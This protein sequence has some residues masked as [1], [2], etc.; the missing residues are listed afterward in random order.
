MRLDA[1]GTD[2]RPAAAMRDAEGLVQV[3]VADV[4]AELGRAH[5]PDLGIEVGAV[6][7]DLTAIGMDG[8]ADFLDRRLEHAMGRGIGDHQGGEVVLVLG[9]LL[10]QVGDVDVAM[11]VAGHDDDLHARHDGGGRVG[12]MGRDG[13]EADVALSFT[14]RGVIAADGEQARIFALAAGIGLQRHGV[15][16]GDLRQHLLQLLEELLVAL[17]LFEGGE[18]MQHGEAAP[19]DGDH[20]RRGVELHGAGTQRNH[21][22][23]ERHVLHLQ[24]AEVAQHLG[25]R[26]IHREHRVGEVA[27][28]PAQWLR[29]RL[30]HLGVDGVD[31]DALQ[32]IGLEHAQQPFQLLPA[33]RLV[34]GD[35]EVIGIDEAQVDA[36]FLG[37]G[38]QRMRAAGGM[39]GD[40]VEERLR[41]HLVAEACHRGGEDFRHAVGALGHLPDALRPVVDGE[42]GGDD[43][44]EHLCRAD[45]A[46]RLLA[47]DVLLARLQRHAQRTVALG[48][49]RDADDAA[50]HGAL[51]FVLGGE[52][53]G[54][55]AAIAHGHAEALG[56]ADGDVGAQFTGR[57]QQ[58]QGE[59]VGRHDGQRTGTMELCDHAAE[60]AHLA[61]GAGIG[62]EC[63]EDGLGL[64]V[65]HRVADDDVI[66]K[67]PR[68]RLDHANCL[69][70]R[71][72]IDEETV[73][74]GLHHALRH[75]H[76]L[77]RRGALVEQRGIG[78]FEAGH[79]DDHLLEVQQ[80]L[81]AAL[82][83][84]RLVGRVGGVPAGVLQHVAQDD[85][86]RDGAVV[87]HADHRD[88]DVVP[89]RHGAEI[90]ECGALRHRLL[91]FERPLGADVLRHHAGDE[92]LERGGAE[93]LQHLG[94]VGL[95]GTDVTGNEI[96]AGFE[97]GECRAG[98]HDAYPFTSLS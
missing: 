33:H 38:P 93:A 58:R 22:L 43:G 32:R 52:E 69:R 44:E 92:V 18:G 41:H 27:R 70:V 3:H 19:G 55:R 85:L 17:R 86:G 42:H 13:D 24:V 26:M 78:D 9:G 77:G 59:K 6:E 76:R 57:R 46:R 63:G 53:G 48:I 84:L 67:G 36:L 47:A 62:E 50:R 23:V 15:E 98:G 25:F 16:A 61:R 75:A 91:E 79:V 80:R 11:L 31:R 81:E 66:A 8:V 7:I 82:A 64:Q 88:E 74:R 34:E 14:A 4:G 72:A 96:G 1:D 39:D 35:A 83:H 71:V 28:G 40:R 2:T 65:L 5:E 95:V 94:G 49:D 89:L 30:L 97:L 29:D 21:R 68:A 37:P 10:L 87:A 54:M 51:V 73:G 60:I 56:R 12:A 45:V 90:G 20:L